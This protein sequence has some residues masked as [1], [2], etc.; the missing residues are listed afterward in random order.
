MLKM[1]L[2]GHSKRDST[3][4]PRSHNGMSN[5]LQLET[6]ACG[7]GTYIYQNLTDTLSGSTYPGTMQLP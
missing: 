6:E 2:S 1:I 4:F 3:M 5:D 7:G